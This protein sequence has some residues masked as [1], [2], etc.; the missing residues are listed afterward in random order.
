VRPASSQAPAVAHPTVAEAGER[1]R[2]ILLV[3]DHKPTSVALMHLLVS[4]NYS[5]ITAGCVAEAREA[6][7]REDFDLLI[8][9]IGLP[10]GDGYE[11]MMELQGRQPLVGIALTGYGME[12]DVARSQHAGFVTHL[13]KP[14]SVHAL[15]NALSAA[16]HRL[17]VR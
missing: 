5:V 2:R 17:S 14:V 15:D 11:L 10:D 1:P 7:D 8:S 3:E 12:Q 6:A 9:D 13:T 4:R 16:H